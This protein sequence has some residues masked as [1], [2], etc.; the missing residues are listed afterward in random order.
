[1]MD[2]GRIGLV[3]GCV[4][5][6]LCGELPLYVAAAAAAAAA[7]AKEQTKTL[8]LSCALCHSFPIWIAVWRSYDRGGKYCK[9]QHPPSTH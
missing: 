4:G 3:E 1:M 8:K 7:E 9:G 6:E 5:G 2:G